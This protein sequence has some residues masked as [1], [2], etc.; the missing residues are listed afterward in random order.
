MN[1]PIFSNPIADRIPAT[2]PTHIEPAGDVMISEQVP[3]ATPPARVA[4]IIIVISSLP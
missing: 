2:N 1:G 4:F 3:I